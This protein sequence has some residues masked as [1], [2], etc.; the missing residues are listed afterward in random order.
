MPIVSFLNQKGG[1]G[2]TTLC[3]NIARDFKLRGKKT[4]LVDTDPQGSALDWHVRSDGE[5]ID[6]VCLSKPTLNKDVPK[7]KE[8]YDWIFIDGI[9]K[10]DEMASSAIACSD[11][12]LIPVHPSPYDIWSTK[13]II[14]LVKSRQI[15]A[16]EQ[17]KASFIVSMQINNTNLSKEVKSQLE[18]YGFPVMNGRTCTRVAYAECL[19]NGSTIHEWDDLKALQ[20]IKQLSLEIEEFAHGIT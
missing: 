14:E 20:E 10:I 16:D 12:V 5:L 18:E 7:F 8:M 11:V 9:G 3:L 6:M 19:N 4:L 15:I 2:K 17:P 1:V 13:K